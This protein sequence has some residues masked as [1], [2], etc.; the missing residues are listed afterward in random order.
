[1]SNKKGELKQVD[2]K[3]MW[4][5]GNKWLIKETCYDREATPQNIELAKKRLKQLN[6]QREESNN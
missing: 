2:N 3:I 1:M 6:A 4:F 5:N